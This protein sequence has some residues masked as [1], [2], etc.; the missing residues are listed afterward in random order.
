MAFRSD[1]KTVPKIASEFLK[2]CGN[3]VQASCLF[4]P[5]LGFFPSEGKN[6]LALWWGQVDAKE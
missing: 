5:I 6:R 4:S 3:R 1:A 2:P